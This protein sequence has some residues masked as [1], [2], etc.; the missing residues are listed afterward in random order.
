MQ[1]DIDKIYLELLEY[2]KTLNIIDA[3]E[4]FLSEAEHLTRYLS[5]YDYLA[6]YVKGY[7]QFK[8]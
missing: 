8:L 3:H 6:A 2:S 7:K 1:K 4:H 5:F